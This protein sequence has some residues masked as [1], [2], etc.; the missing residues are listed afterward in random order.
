M[1]CILFYRQVKDLIILTCGCLGLSYFTKYFWFLWLL[2]PLK[3]LYYAWSK[4]LAPWFFAP[5]PET[6]AADEKKAKKLDRR[7]RR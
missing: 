5:A 3:G 1:F 4:I 2:V 6:S 7:M